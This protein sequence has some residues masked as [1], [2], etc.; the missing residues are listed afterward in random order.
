M[1]NKV[2]KWEF[3]ET[4]F[5]GPKEGNPFIEVEFTAIFKNQKNSIEITGFYDGYGEYKIRFM[6]NMIGTWNFITHS[7]V[8]SLNNLTGNFECIEPSKN[9]HGP[10][11]VR[12][13]FHFEY[14]DKTPHYS[15]GTTCYAWIHQTESLQLQTL[16]TLKFSPFNK[17]RM[18]VFP[19]SYDYNHNEPDLYAYEG[20]IE[21]GFNYKKF[22]PNFFK[23]LENR[24][25]NL[26]NLGIECDLILFHPY[27]RWGFSE[28]GAKNDELYLKYIVSRLSAFRNIWWSMANE[29]DI[30]VNQG[31]K[32]LNDWERLAQLVQEYDKYDHL[33]SIHNCNKFYDYNKPWI[34]HCS[35]QRIDFYRTS[36]NTDEWR[37]LYDKPIVIDECAYEGNI[38]HGWG[39]ITGQEMTRRFWE[40]VVR[41][42]YVG[43][44]ETYIHPKDILWWS[45]G[46]TLHGTS[47]A[48]IAFLRRI[49]ENAPGPITSPVKS[50]DGS[51]SYWD[52][53]VGSVSDDYFLFY[54]GFC[55]PT[56]R[57]FNMPKEKKYK[58]DIIDTWE[59]T[60]TE[61]GIYTE[62]FSIDMPGK[63]YI[64]IRMI[65]V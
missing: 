45:H 57:T 26:Q 36:E 56:F 11:K 20:S 54:F 37:K 6:P 43:H 12:D 51:Y 35:I 25:L 16:K 64:A 65:R 1:N 10:V 14:A 23:H 44:G 24:I 3:Y 59:M 19:K 41:G 22:N 31:K 34:T 15:F 46:G 2:E 53:T 8:N 63:Q 60:I 9:N 48:R 28:M 29:Y 38:N 40:G 27:D 42:G 13:K 33:N 18:C 50:S 7:N 62:D 39:N 55:Q 32:T 49:L 58:V 4:T 61:A 52:V 5:K 21:S 30:L 17:L 47:P